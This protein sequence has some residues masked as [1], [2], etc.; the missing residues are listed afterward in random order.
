MKKEEQQKNQYGLI[1]MIAIIIGTVVGSGIYVK[2]NA[3][4]AGTGSS[5]L[6]MI[7]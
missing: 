3:V 5:I 7:A 4:M 2:N 6:S 1:S